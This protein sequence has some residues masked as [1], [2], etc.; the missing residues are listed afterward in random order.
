[1]IIQHYINRAY[2]RQRI[3]KVIWGVWIKV[4]FIGIVLIKISGWIA[5]IIEANKEI[6]IYQR[7][8]EES[9]LKLINIRLNRLEKMLKEKEKVTENRKETIKGTTSWYDYQLLSDSE[10]SKKHLTAAVR[11]FPRGTILAVCSLENNCIQVRVNDYGP[12][13]HTGRI[14]DLS[15]H[16]FQQL[17]PL[18]KGVIEVTIEKI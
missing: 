14:I 4:I 5:G 12:Q 6:E 3:L 15:S 11:N 17:A 8:T 7:Q 2:E 13:E 16:A 9:I 1:M 18:S 10:Y